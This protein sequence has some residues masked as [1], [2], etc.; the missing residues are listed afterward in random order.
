MSLIIIQYYQYFYGRMEEDQGMKW[1]G[2]KSLECFIEIGSCQMIMI[3]NSIVII[4][5]ISSSNDQ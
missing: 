3:N 4:I 1:L 5:V 2:F